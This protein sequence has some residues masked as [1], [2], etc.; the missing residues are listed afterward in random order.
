MED[1][2]KLLAEVNGKKIYSNDVYA[3]MANIEGGARFQN[4]EGIKVLADEMVNQ[5]ILLIDAY[6]MGINKDEDFEKELKNLEPG[7]EVEEAESAIYNHDMTDVT[8]IIA[9]ILRDVKAGR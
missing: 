3:F 5:E 1:N 4:E 2:N 8:D 9:E 7:L 6:K